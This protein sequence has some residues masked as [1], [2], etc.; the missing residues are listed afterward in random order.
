MRLLLLLLVL[1]LLLLLLPVVVVLLLVLLLVLLAHDILLAPLS[2][3]GPRAQGFLCLFGILG[4]TD[5]GLNQL[6]EGCGHSLCTL[7]VN[8]CC[9]IEIFRDRAALAALFPRVHTWVVHS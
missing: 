2:P 9:N 5:A 4:L 8:G 7:D 1:V 6:S 3:P